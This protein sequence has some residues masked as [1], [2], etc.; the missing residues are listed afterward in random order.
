MLATMDPALLVALGEPNRL[1]IVE[2]LADAPRPVGEIAAALDLRQPQATKHLQTLHR[3]GLVTVHPLG[4][5]RIYALRREPLRELA[6]WLAG[7]ASDHPSEGELERYAAAIAAEGAHGDAPP[8]RS[9]AF[10]RRFPATP[11]AVWNAWTRAEEVVRWWAPDHFTVVE[12]EVAAVPGGALR[13]VM[14]EGDGTRYAAV[15]RFLDLERPAS[16]RF[17][18][19]PVDAE[20]SPL[21]AAVHRLRLRRRRGST[22]LSLEMDVTRARPEAAP[23]LAGLE[24]GW[25]QLLDNLERHLAADR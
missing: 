12:C 11:V 3:A 21:F 13:I 15:G 4:R 14:A 8:D 6:S 5:R 16:L 7:F 1:R 23:A 22:E 20:G 24:P 9:L 2:L 19:A 18:L 25:R 17:E 10:A